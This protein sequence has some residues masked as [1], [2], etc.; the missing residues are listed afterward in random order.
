M[1]AN[2]LAFWEDIFGHCS[3]RGRPNNKFK[4]SSLCLVGRGG[5]N[6]RNSPPKDYV[7]SWVQIDLLSGKTSLGTV[8]TGTDLITCPAS[9]RIIAF[10]SLLKTG[11][12]DDFLMKDSRGSL[13]PSAVLSIAVGRGIVYTSTPDCLKTK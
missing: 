13:D 7:L 4:V 6:S 5:A 3:N 1:V 10:E 11:D 8:P 12:D 9:G 2:E